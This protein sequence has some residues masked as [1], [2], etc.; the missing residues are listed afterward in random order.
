M[1][2][3]DRYGVASEHGARKRRAATMVKVFRCGSRRNA[4]HLRDH[5]PRWQTSQGGS[6][7]GLA[8]PMG[9]ER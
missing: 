8:L 3:N 4:V 2:L 7:G 5:D 6:G 9:K 1:R